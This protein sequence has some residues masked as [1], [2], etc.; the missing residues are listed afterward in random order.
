MGA[1]DRDRTCAFALDRL[2]ARLDRRRR[3]RLVIPFFKSAA[4][5]A[6]MMGE[7]RQSLAARPRPDYERRS[8]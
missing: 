1:S 8:Q 5:A 6:P 2:A 4:S 3:L 7:A